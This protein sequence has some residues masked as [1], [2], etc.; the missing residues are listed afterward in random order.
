M[1]AVLPIAVT[2]CC[3]CSVALQQ[4]LRAQAKLNEVLILLN[5][6]RTQPQ[7]F[8]DKRLM[9]YLEQNGLEENSY[10]K[11]LVEELRTRKPAD[12]L[13]LSLALNAVAKAHAI[14]MGTKNKV[15]HNSSNGTTFDK[16]LR[17]RAKA[18]GAIAEN[19]DYGNAKPLDIVMSLLIDDGIASLGHRKNILEPRLHFVGI[20][21]EPHKKYGVNCVMDFAEGF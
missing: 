18:K 17:Q 3:V 4:P 2:F 21:I 10:S 15:G 8:L 7:Q 9:P 14:D 19:C 6:V 11:S 20:A 13:T 12:S 16:R 5:E 1:R